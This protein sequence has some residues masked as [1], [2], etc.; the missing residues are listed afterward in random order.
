MGL[1]EV[2]DEAGE[3]VPMPAF[4]VWYWWTAFAAS[5]HLAN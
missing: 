2:L 5:R 1:E 3:T 4:H